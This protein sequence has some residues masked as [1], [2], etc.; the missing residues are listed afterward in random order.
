M[1]ELLFLAPIVPFP[2][3]SLPSLL[4]PTSYLPAVATMSI[5]EVHAEAVTDHA[6]V[7][8][9]TDDGKV[10]ALEWSAEHQAEVKLDKTH[11]HADKHSQGKFHE[12]S[13]TAPPAAHAHNYNVHL[14]TPIG[15]RPGDAKIPAKDWHKS[16]TEHGGYTPE[17]LNH[18]LK[19]EWQKSGTG[20]A[21]FHDAGSF[22]HHVL[23]LLKVT[24]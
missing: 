15:S 16:Q 20:P 21:S 14:W 22:V 13:E 4:K 17:K 23:N 5:T 6:M 19:H 9:R 12:K 7:Y 2:A 1:S 8:L 11:A 24:D 10:H 18:D 3:G